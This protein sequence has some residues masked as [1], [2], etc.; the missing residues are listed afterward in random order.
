M[1]NLGGSFN[2]FVVVVGIGA[3]TVVAARLSANWRGVAAHR[4]AVADTERRAARVVRNDTAILVVSTS[5]GEHAEAVCVERGWYVI[6]AETENP[7][8]AAFAILTREGGIDE[9]R[10]ITYVPRQRGDAAV[11]ESEPVMLLER[12]YSLTAESAWT[13]RAWAR[14]RPAAR[15]HR[16]VK[17]ARPHEGL[18]QHGVDQK[19]RTLSLSDDV[20]RAAAYRHDRTV[21]V[22]GSADG[23]PR[24]VDSR[25]ERGNLRGKR[26]S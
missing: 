8:T 13:R 9:G 14:I 5:A 26:G 25:S 21:T 17:A 10:F 16:T 2:R 23:F 15:L 19:N 7:D 4:A 18:D 12:C 22:R 24:P 1:L 3:L 11:V 20:G 6:E